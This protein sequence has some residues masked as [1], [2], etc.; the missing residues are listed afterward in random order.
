MELRCPSV[1]L[2]S[3]SNIHAKLVTTRLPRRGRSLSEADAMD[4]APCCLGVVR[5]GKGLA[6]REITL[7][8]APAYVSWPASDAAM[9]AAST[10]SVGVL[11]VHDIWGFNIPN[12]K[13]IADHMAANGMTAILPNLYHGISQIDGWSGDEFD[14]GAPLEGADWEAWWTQITG[15]A[16]WKAFHERINASVRCLRE[17]H[18]CTKLCVIGFCWGGLAIEQ[19]A[20]RGD[21]AQA[22]SVHGCHEAA[23]N[24]LAAKASGCQIVYHTVSGDE[25]FPVGAQEQLRAAGASVTVYEGMEHGFA[26]RGD[27]AHNAELKAA[28]DKCLA[29]AVAQFAA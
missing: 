22:A 28:A 19:L 2:L 24:F 11:V 7:G 25:S 3:L 29:S 27:F 18:G 20:T 13:Y 23:D 5:D 14:D 17:E 8:G 16:Y 15:E 10:G 21:F 12:A 1:N 9:A 4:A 6:G 26:V